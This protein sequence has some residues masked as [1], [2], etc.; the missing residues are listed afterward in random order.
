M[1]HRRERGRERER[2]GKG[3]EA[4]IALN[5]LKRKKWVT[6]TTIYLKSKRSYSHNAPKMVGKLSTAYL[7]MG[8]SNIFINLL[9]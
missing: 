5:G 9:G 7:T 3:Y 4:K 2:E 8:L 1:M 6:T